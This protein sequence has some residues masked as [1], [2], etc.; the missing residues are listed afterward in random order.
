MS[1]T[2]K[3][4]IS[5]L[6]DVF[7]GPGM[8]DS[9]PAIMGRVKMSRALVV[10]DAPLR[11]MGM[12]DR[13][14]IAA[15]MRA[16]VFDDVPT[17]PTESSV[18]AGLEV[19]RAHD[20]DG[21]IALGGGSPIDCAKA[22]ALLVTHPRPLEQYAFIRGG[23]DRITADQPPLIAVPT[24]AG[25][26]SE[27]GRGSVMTLSSGV[28]LSLISPHL[29]PDA[30][31][32]D[33]NLTLDMPP[34]LTAATG[35]D[36]LSHCV[37]TYCS[38]SYN[39]VADAIALDGFVRAWS[40]IRRAVAH[41]DDLR[42]RTEMMMAAMQG[43]LTFQKGLGAVHALSHPLGSLTAKRLHHGTLNA[44]FMPHVLRFNMDA[45]RERIGRLAEAA[46]LRQPEALPEAF[47]R[48]SAELG[49]PLRLSQLG[50]SREDLTPLVAHAMRDHCT[51]TNPRKPTEADYQ[52]LY[53]AAL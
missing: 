27:V 32:C 53:D 28:K 3:P 46:G 18:L 39:P 10:T 29:Y 8:I 23:L 50:V 7:F 45:G 20:C 36:A 51:W 5:Y 17:N 24:T 33:P 4:T 14:P 1:T 47:E 2:L 37:E 52:S 6:N 48:L 49:L 9:L 12:V 22:I 43:G 13:L 38:P 26:G 35:M 15:P 21:V 34:T 16:A 41:G 42:A 40:N 30:A 11:A 25:T 19:Y 44:I 31:L